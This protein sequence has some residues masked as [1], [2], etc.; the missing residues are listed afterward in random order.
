M[1]TTGFFC[2]GIFVDPCVSWNVVGWQEFFFDMGPSI[3]DVGNWEEGGVINWS[4]LQMDS[5]NKLPTW[6]RGVSKIRK[7]C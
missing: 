6:G 5:T 2:H 1:R 4:K 7:N 3:N